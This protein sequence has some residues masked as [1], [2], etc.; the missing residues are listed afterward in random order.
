MPVLAKRAE[1]YTC[2]EQDRLQVRNHK[3]H[4]EILYC[5]KK[6]ESQ[7]NITITTILA[8]IRRL[9]KCLKKALTELKR[10]M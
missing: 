10:V 1:S 6:V 8:P 4:K 5:E 3:R 7:E 9:P 2:I